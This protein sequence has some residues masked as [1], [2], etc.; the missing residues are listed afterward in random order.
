MN[1]SVCAVIL[2]QSLNRTCR[3]SVLKRYEEKEEP[4]TLAFGLLVLCVNFA[5]TCW[6]M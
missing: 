6:S 3:T 4:I 1:Q 5:K 2:L